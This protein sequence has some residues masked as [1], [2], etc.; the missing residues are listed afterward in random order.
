MSPLGVACMPFVRDGFGLVAHG[1]EAWEEP[2]FSRRFAMRRARFVLAVS[3]YTA[4]ALSRATGVRAT[5]M[6]LLP[7]TLDPGFEEMEPPADTGDD[8]P[9]ELLVVT[10]LWAE[11]KL[12]GVDH[13]IEAFARLV[14]R[15][16]QARLRIV[17]KGSDKPR[18]VALA[19]TLG[20]GQ[21]VTFEE[22]LS[23]AELS[24]RYRRCAA[25]VMPS[26]QEGF[27]IVFLEAMRFAKPCVGGDTG[28]TPEVIEEGRTGYLVPYGDVP[29][30]VQALERLL[31]DA[32]LRRRMGRAGLVRL[33]QEFTFPRFR[34]RLE[35]HLRELLRCPAEGPCR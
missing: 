24:G 27:G 29:A 5:A 31:V 9:P 14:A 23:D 6:R 16:P 15:H 2:R 26:G 25:F 12:K 30:L 33:Q 13:T 1:I 20:L 28:G 32:E 3:A 22:D 7:N 4:S 10:R 17:G 21:R 8:G 35:G 11:E 19:G 34:A 18:L